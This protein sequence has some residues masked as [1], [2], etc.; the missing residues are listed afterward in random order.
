MNRLNKTGSAIFKFWMLYLQRILFNRQFRDH[1]NCPCARVAAL[2]S[3]P[4]H[5]YSVVISYF[6]VLWDCTVQHLFESRVA[7]N[8]G[9][10][11][12]KN[13]ASVIISHEQTKKN[14]SA[15]FK[16]YM[17]YFQRILFTDNLETTTAV[18]VSI[19]RP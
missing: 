14:E 11:G 13:V 4:V 12:V 2:K 3:L 7:L 17:L 18:V 10:G 9:L 15:V 6:L 1:N 5:R 8:S 19:W 16:L